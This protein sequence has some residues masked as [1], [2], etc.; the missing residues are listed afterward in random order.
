MDDTCLTELELISRFV[1]TAKE[2]INF[3]LKTLSEALPDFVKFVWYLAQNQTTH[4][5][6]YHSHYN[7]LLFVD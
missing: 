6:K 7:F 2:H 4:I 5:S 3:F 1:K